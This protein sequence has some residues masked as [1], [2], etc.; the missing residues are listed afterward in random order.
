[1][2]ES[3]GADKY[4]YFGVDGPAAEAVQL[5]EVATESAVGE[6]EFVARVPVHS[7]AAVDETLQLALDPDNVMIFDPRTGANLSVAMVDA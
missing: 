1:M 7:A 5:A 6:N 3:L 2:V 4:V